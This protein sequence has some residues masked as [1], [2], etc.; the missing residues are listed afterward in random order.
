MISTMVKQALSEDVGSG[1]ITAELMDAD[2][3]V[4][5]TI[6]TRESAVVCG[7]AWVNETFAQIDPR[8]KITWLVNDADRVIA[9]QRLCSVTGSARSIL[10]S[11]RTVLNF[12]QLLSATATSTAQYVEKISH[13]STCLL[14]TRK[15]L[16]LYREAQKYAVTCGGGQNHRMGLYDMFL[17]KEN[18][19]AS[20]GSITAAV[21]KARFLYPDK[22]VEVEVETLT[23]YNEALE[24]KPD[25]IMLDNFSIPDIRLAVSQKNDAIKLEI[26]G[27]V[28]LENIRDYA[29]L[30]V[31]YISVGAITK[32][33]NAIDLSMRVHS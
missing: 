3:V 16:P 13:T 23:E 5:A 19:I 20:C 31:D 2:T 22:K 14:D 27:N 17:I 25:I 26:S 30:G 12:L 18:H 10:T 1:D 29:E 28:T 6:I 9:N 32:H 7:V 33:I 24:V 11:E 15:T 8:V 4:T 21:N